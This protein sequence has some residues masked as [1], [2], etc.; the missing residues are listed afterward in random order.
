MY[1]ILRLIVKVKFQFTFDVMGNKYSR[2]NFNCLILYLE[3]ICFSLRVITL[4]YR[5][6][7]NVFY[8]A[9]AVLILFVISPEDIKK[10][11]CVA[12]CSFLY[13]NIMKLIL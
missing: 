12:A 5:S 8:Q 6:S 13:L 7:V 4:A 2:R 10:I 3:N 1:R 11:Y 9:F